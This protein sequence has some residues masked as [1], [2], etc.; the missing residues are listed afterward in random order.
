MDPRAVIS[1]E[2]VL[3]R[4]GITPEVSFATT[5]VT[6]GKTARFSTATQGMIILRHL[7][8]EFFFGFTLNKFP[9]YTVRVAT[10]EKALLD[11]LWFHRFEKDPEPY[12][13]ELRLT[14]P[15]QFSWKKFREYSRVYHN[16]YLARLSAS[17]IK[18]YAHP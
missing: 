18:I 13:R 14:I 1:L 15:P 16:I 3:H 11:L 4:A 7:K 5:A 17:V 2:T 9:P 10:P 6:P 8:S 12:V